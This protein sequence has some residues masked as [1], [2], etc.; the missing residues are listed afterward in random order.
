MGTK[1]WPYLCSASVRLDPE[2]HSFFLG[3]CW[4]MERTESSNSEDGVLSDVLSFY[5]LRFGLLVYKAEII[6][7]P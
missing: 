7:L 3:H 2:K 1:N 6:K 5:F 4:I